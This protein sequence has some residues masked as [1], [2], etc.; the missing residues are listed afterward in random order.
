MAPIVRFIL[1]T[2]CRPSE[3]CRLTWGMFGPGFKTATL[4]QHKTAAKTGRPRT[5]YLTPE[6]VAIVTSSL[7]G[8]DK[9]DPR[10][11]V[12]ISARCEAYTPAGIRS[13]VKRAAQLALGRDLGPYVFRHTFAQAASRL[14]PV[15][16]L[17][18]LMGHR[19]IVT[20]QRYYDVQD[21]T[22]L[23]AAAS[24]TGLVPPIPPGQPPATP[25]QHADPKRR[26]RPHRGSA[27]DPACRTQ[28]A[29][30]RHAE[31]QPGRAR[32]RAQASPSKPGRH[33][34]QSGANR[35]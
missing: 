15:D 3:A 17:A 21:D 25:E 1:A 29:A 11:P 26:K 24:V 22:A 31:P 19:S 12:F 2:G 35:P 23:A 9:P 4:A 34:K 16:H 10:A 32:A 14:V 33:R 20:T 28:T 13:A 8:S 27:T 30:E 7:P 5:I 6:A 18:K